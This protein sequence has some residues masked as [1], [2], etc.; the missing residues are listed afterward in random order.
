MEIQKIELTFFQKIELTF[1]TRDAT[2]A[3]ARLARVALNRPELLQGIAAL[4]EDLFDSHARDVNFAHRDERKIELALTPSPAFLR[5]LKAIETLD[6]D[7]AA[8]HR[9]R[10]SNFEGGEPFGGFPK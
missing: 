9:T 3:L 2:R 4:E 8:I 1:S 6:P 10:D 7:V 5:F